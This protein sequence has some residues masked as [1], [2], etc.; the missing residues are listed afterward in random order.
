VA[1]PVA[2]PAIKKRDPRKGEHHGQSSREEAAV[3]PFCID[4]PE[5]D[6][7]D[8]R[9]RI[10]ATHWPERETVDDSAQGVQLATNQELARYWATD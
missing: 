7:V 3:R 2:Q 6:L 5:E 9:R 4:A 1:E 8:L 10:L